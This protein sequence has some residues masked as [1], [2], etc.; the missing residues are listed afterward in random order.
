MAEPRLSPRSAARKPVGTT[1][2]CAIIPR[3]CEKCALSSRRKVRERRERLHES[4]G[5]LHRPGRVLGGRCL[6]W[7]R[8]VIDDI[9]QVEPSRQK[10]AQGGINTR[11]VGG[12]QEEGVLDTMMGLHRPILTLENIRLR[13]VKAGQVC[14]A[15]GVLGQADVEHA[16]APLQHGPRIGD[17]LASLRLHSVMPSRRISRIRGE[18][19]E[20]SSARNGLASM[21]APVSSMNRTLRSARR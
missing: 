21:N 18:R 14:G 3:Q 2:P 5:D 9:L 11:V 19:F 15:S 7:V 1:M 17:E 10:V 8:C 16:L 20:Y 13:C 4:G 6:A 12:Q